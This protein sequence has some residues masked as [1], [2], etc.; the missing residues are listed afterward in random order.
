MR[1][2][3][4]EDFKY[5][6]QDTNNIY[7]GAK[8]SYAEILEN[9]EI[10]FKYKAIVEHYL[11]RDATPDSTLESEF[12]YM[13]ASSFSYKTYE[14]LR[15]RLKISRIVTRKHLFGGK[16]E[17]YQEETLKLHEFVAIPLEEKKQEGIIVE[18][19]ILPKFALLSFAV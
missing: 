1:S 10:N 15:V 18:E 4:Y 11:L 14:Q 2:T 16:K 17:T 13:D 9:R 3:Q 5:S 7:V 12:Y 8:F 19:L 6:I